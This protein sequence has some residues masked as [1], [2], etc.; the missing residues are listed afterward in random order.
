MGSPLNATVKSTTANSYLTVARATT[1]LRRRLH[2][3]VW[4]AAS[5]TPSA[6]DYQT[7]G[8]ALLAATSVAID[9]GEGAWTAGTVFQ[10]TSHATEYTVSAALTGAGTLTFT[11]G[12]TQALVD[13][14][15]LLRQ[16]ANER[17]RALMTAT[18]YLDMMMVWNGRKRTNT[19]ALWFPATGIVNENGD[20]YDYDLIPFPLE[21]ATSE[22]ANY[23]LRKD[24]FA[25]S[26]ALGLGISEAQIGP[27]K[28]KIDSS[29]QTAVI[30]DNI[31]A[32]LSQLGVLEPEAQ[33][34]STVVPLRRV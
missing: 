14:D 23:L 7:N 2:T 4:D 11:P 33:K 15:V 22:F 25:P 31:L 13:G 18:T 29:Q 3:E 24:V 19:Q 12:L 20:A 21:V 10:F 28:A 16:T 1:L 8:S 32:L 26:K 17:E 5:S 6:N 27:L 30:P 9:T 34:G